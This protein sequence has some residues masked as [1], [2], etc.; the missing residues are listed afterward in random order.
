MVFDTVDLHFLRETREAELRRDPQLHAAAARTR[1]QEL[2]L[3]RTADL[4][5]VVSPVELEILENECPWH[6]V[7]IFP[8]IY[9][10]GEARPYRDEARNIVFIGSFE[11]PPNVDAVL[12]FARRSFP[13]SWLAFPTPFSR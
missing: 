12:H 11:H 6:D 13:R 8:T 10:L 1:K 9:R 2:R 4:T 3:V 5:L 7:R